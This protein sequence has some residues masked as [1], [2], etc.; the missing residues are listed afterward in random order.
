[1]KHILKFLLLLVLMIPAL[2]GWGQITVFSDNF[3]TNTNASWTTSGQIGTS[4]W[5][6]DRNADDW[7]ARRSTSPEQLELTNDA[8]NIIMQ[9]VGY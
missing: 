1:M 7:G 2:T 5:Y 4:A 9:M 6:V 3:S 8:N